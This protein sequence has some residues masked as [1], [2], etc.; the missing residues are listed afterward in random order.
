MATASATRFTQRGIAGISLIALAITLAIVFKQR[1]E[2]SEELKHGMHAVAYS[3][4]L[5]GIAFFNSYVY[6]TDFAKMKNTLFSLGVMLVIMVAM[7]LFS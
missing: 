2:W 7:A 6:Q 3:A 5:L 4:G 1:S